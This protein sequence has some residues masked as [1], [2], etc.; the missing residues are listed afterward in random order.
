M[1]QPFDYKTTQDDKFRLID[2]NVI[3]QDL[4]INYL[5]VKKVNTKQAAH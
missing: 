1:N 2:N 5:N 4:L 3:V